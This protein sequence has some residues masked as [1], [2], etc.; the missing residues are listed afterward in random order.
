M[1]ERLPFGEVRP[2]A[3]PINA[4]IQPAQFNTAGAARP[5]QLGSP[6]GITTLQQARTPDVRGFNQ[7]EQVAEAL[8]PFSKNLSALMEKGLVS[9]ATSK[10]DAGYADQL[11]KLENEKAKANLSLQVQSE[12]GATRAAGTITQLQKVDPIAAQLLEESNP[13]AL[14]GRK[15]A[16]AQMAAGQIESVLED[17]LTNNAGALSAIKPGSPQLMQRKYQLTQQLLKPYGLTLDEPEA[18]FYIAPRLNKAWEQ[19]ADKQRGFFQK[20]RDNSTIATGTAAMGV[21]IQQL[22]RDGIPFNGQVIKAGD[23]LFSQLAGAVLTTELDTQLGMLAGE[24]KIKALEEVRKQLVS[25]YGRVPVLA[26]ALTFIRGGDRSMPFEK[27]PTWGASYPLDMIEL[28]NRGNDSRIKEYQL[29]QQSM[30][31]GLDGAWF[32]KG[33][34]GSMLPSDPGYPAALLRFRQEGSGMGYR[35]ID[36]YMKKRMDSLEA[37][38]SQAYR[39]SPFLAQDFLNQIE[40]LPPS[41]FQSA[42]GIAEIRKRALDAAMA[43][44]TPELQAKRYSEY[45]QRID[46][47]RKQAEDFTPGVKQQIDSAI[48]QDLALPEIK[49]MADAAKPNGSS[50]MSSLLQNGTDPAT[51]MASV[52]GSSKLVAFTNGV[53]NLF[54]RRAEDALN[55]WRE[56]HPGQA[57]SPAAKNRIV[58]QA[59]ADTRKSKEYADLYTG[60]TSKKPGEVGPGTVG[61]GPSQGTQPGPQARGVPRN[62]ARALPDSTVKG[63]QVRPV[64]E[65]SWLHSE[66]SNVAAGRPV[67]PEL[68][69]M[70]RRAGSSTTRYLLE[71]LR[72]Y[73]QLDPQGD[74]RRFLQ[75]EAR[76][77]REGNT[78]SS[79]N[80]GNSLSSET[81][82]N[83]LAPGSWL[84]SM[85]MPPAAAATLPPGYSGGGQSYVATRSSGGG[86]PRGGSGGAGWDN[87][88][89]MARAK[90]AKFPELVA[91]QWA[92]ESDWGR[93][94]SGRNNFFGQKGPGTTKATWEVVN[95]R[96]VN[97][98]ASFMDF[99]SPSDSVGY[100][101]SK[102]YQG[103][104]GANNA[105]TVEEA[106]RILKQQGYATDPAYVNKLLRIIRSNRRP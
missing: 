98:S 77:Q 87:V 18:Q 30:E 73:P 9:Y 40:D 91:A 49:K 26:E 4:F 60:L 13:W 67:S 82:Y 89:A 85:L 69:E 75:Q 16:I 92:L 46:E 31:E 33:M 21:K 6:Q 83:P 55:T 66:L 86:S 102:W 101:V 79:A 106:A 104:G 103:R 62:A 64:M 10:I 80:F 28:K 42:G 23:P 41:S 20:E 43:E 58:S 105:R 74:A 56:D 84:M 29:G 51:A 54:M 96:R 53:Q 99:A 34:P 14:I 71:Q 2:G 52:F 61:T 39:P 8:A 88:V 24:G 68:Y 45:N 11:K 47:R 50:L 12:Q 44:P 36:G 19:Y 7:F 70:A 3:R 35:D 5:D 76:R 59:I 90:G 72:F 27:R 78:V 97:T 17:D 65:G 22:V 15:R 25:T 1:A 81:P 93:A 63:F 38:T 94:T 48:L 57:M 100:L 95:G 32:A 37:V